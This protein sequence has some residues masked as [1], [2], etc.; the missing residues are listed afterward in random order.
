MQPDQ[1]LMLAVERRCT[2]ANVHEVRQLL[3]LYVDHCFVGQA[4]KAELD[5]RKLYRILRRAS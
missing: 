3:Q 4:Q 2:G 5:K 1:G